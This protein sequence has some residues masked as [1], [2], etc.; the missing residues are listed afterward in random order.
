MTARMCSSESTSIR[1]SQIDEDRRGGVRFGGSEPNPQA[2]GWVDILGLEVAAREAAVHIRH[3]HTSKEIGAGEGFVLDKDGNSGLT[4]G[5]LRGS[6][7]R[8]S[9]RSR[10][11]I[12]TH[13]IAAKVSATVRLLTPMRP[14][15]G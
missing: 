10:R 7:T 3:R 13:F 4:A 6:R 1:S 11:A 9:D 14:M 2:H 15:P 8:C 12:D 5:A